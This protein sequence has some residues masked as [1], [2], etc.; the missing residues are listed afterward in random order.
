[1]SD[2]RA[3][4]DAGVVLADHVKPASCVTSTSR[5]SD[6]ETAVAMQLSGSVHARSMTVAPN[7]QV[8]GTVVDHVAPPLAV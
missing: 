4:Q 7:D 5:V 8:S 3:C 1:M 2:E 6:D